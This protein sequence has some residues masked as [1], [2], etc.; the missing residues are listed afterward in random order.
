MKKTPLIE[1]YSAILGE[2]MWHSLTADSTIDNI[3]KA[4]YK[5]LKNILKKYFISINRLKILEVGAYAHFT[6]YLLQKKHKAEVTLTDI[7]SNTLTLGKKIAA[8]QNLYV[9]KKNPRLVVC[10]F[11]DLVFEDN[12]FDV[13]FICSSLHHTWDYNQVV[14]EM[15][16]V[17]APGGLLLL[18]REPCKREACFYKFRT[19]R[20]AALTDFEKKIFDMDLLK[21]FGE[22]YLGSRPETLFGII[23]NQRIPLNDL[24]QE[25][26]NNADIFELSLAIE[27]IMIKEPEREWLSKKNLPLSNLANYIQNYLNQ[28]IDIISPYYSK[29]DAGLGFSLPSQKEVNLF[30]YKIANLIIELPAKYDPNYRIKLGEIFGAEVRIIAQKKF[31][32]SD[33]KKKIHNNL[34][35][36]FAHFNLKM[37]IKKKKYT[38]STNNDL[39]LKPKEYNGI[40]YCL[41]E[42]I[43]DL[44]IKYNSI[45][46]NIQASKP[47]ILHNFFPN[48]FWTFGKNENNITFLSTNISGSKIFLPS[49][50]K[51]LL[52]AL[53]IFA[54]NNENFGYKIIIKHKEEQIY[55][56][57]VYQSESFLFV[58]VLNF[59]M[60]DK[61]RALEIEFR[62]IDPLDNEG[63]GNLFQPLIS[64][65][66]AIGFELIKK[67]N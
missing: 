31:P 41:P 45:I 54:G 61:D 8:T 58:K 49:Q 27:D 9:C 30:A 10:D 48:A 52:I 2:T 1:E 60:H 14:K 64:I 51:R 37:G 5:L 66:S 16:R 22:P 34:L 35:E 29:K 4:H 44:L 20:V 21:T 50:S 18:E 3:S 47:E 32:V 7:S 15:I 17:L 25:I 11:K 43:N 53:R 40:L 19:N 24:L 46:P 33:N 23:E 13:V 62:P 59:S 38:Q 65:S 6:G 42:K 39:Y 56:F 12:T 57:D 26:K 28:K 67:Y 36:K 63:E 55:N